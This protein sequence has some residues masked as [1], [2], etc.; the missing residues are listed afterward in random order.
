MG[1]Y[2]YAKWIEEEVED[3]VKALLLYGIR[4]FLAEFENWLER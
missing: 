3:E 2:L 1:E 4:G